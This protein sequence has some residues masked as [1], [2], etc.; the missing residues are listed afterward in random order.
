MQMLA[1]SPARVDKGSDGQFNNKLGEEILQRLSEVDRKLD[2]MKGWV[3][4]PCTPADGADD[5]QYIII[6][7]SE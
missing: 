6:P 5:S 4:P 3:E 1:N 2:A 7:E